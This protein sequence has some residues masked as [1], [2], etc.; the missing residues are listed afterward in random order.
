M[1]RAFVVVIVYEAKTTSGPGHHIS[2]LGEV[3]ID[4]GLCCV[5]R[6]QAILSRALGPVLVRWRV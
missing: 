1:R 4:E 3:H 2:V 6:S 5:V